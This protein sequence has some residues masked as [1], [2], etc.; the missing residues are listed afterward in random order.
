MYKLIRFFNQNRRK[1]LIVILIIV[2]LLA[3][4][5]LLNY[6]AK[7]DATINVV[8]NN[9]I[10]N[11]TNKQEQLVSNQSAVSGDTISSS[12]LQRD[13]DIIDKFFNFCNDGD[14]NSAYELITDECKEE[15]FPTIEDFINIYTSKVFGNEKKTYTLENWVGDTYAVRISGD[16]LSTGNLDSSQTKQDY[17]T[18]VNDGDDYKLNINNYVGRTVLNKE[19]EN[20]DIKVIINSK[21]TYMDY[22]I[23]DITVENNSENRIA[24]DPN[25]DTKSVYLLD[26]KNMKY[27]FYNNEIVEDTLIVKSKFKTNLKIKFGNSYSSSREIKDVVFSKMILDYDEYLNLEDKSEYNN[28][29]EF[30]ASV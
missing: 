24:L 21:D 15:M 13:T 28:F 22:E 19:T 1:I 14:N 8:T 26:S 30:R 7:N 12:K 23:Y 3:I 10:S 9:N 25:N 27:Y 2:F 5:Q 29:Y 20:Q 6:L 17:I 11:T 18:I 16:I 4:I